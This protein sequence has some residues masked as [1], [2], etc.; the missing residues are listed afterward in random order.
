MARDEILPLIIARMQEY[1]AFKLHSDDD[2]QVRAGKVQPIVIDTKR[3]SGNKKVTHVKNVEKFGLIPSEFAQEA[4]KKFACS[5][6]VQPLP[7]KAKAEEVLIQ[8]DR[9]ADIALYLSTRYNI[10]SKY[11]EEVVGKASSAKK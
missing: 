1:H 8:G 3:V 2:Y 5:S 11:I 7:G 6:G 9:G 10:P 4:Q